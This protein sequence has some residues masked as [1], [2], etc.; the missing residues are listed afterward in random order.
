[1]LLR[2]ALLH[3]HL[4]TRSTSG[5]RTVMTGRPVEVQHCRTPLVA[6]E[7][8]TRSSPPPHHTSSGFASPWPSAG[9]NDL[10]KFLRARL[11]DWKET[12]LPDSSALPAVRACSWLPSSPSADGDGA[13]VFTWLGHAGCHFQIPLPAAPGEDTAV[14]TILTDPVFSKRCSPFQW[15]GPQR[16][17]DPPTSVAEMASSTVAHV[18]PDLLVLSHNHYDHLDHDTMKLLLS[19]PNGKPRPHI[20][21]P[22]GM[23]KWFEKYMSVPKEGVTELDWW[24]DRVAILD[25]NRRVKLTC[26]PA[27]HFSGR[28]L[29]D[30]DQTLW[31]GWTFQALG[32]GDDDDKQGKR[33]Y[34]AGDTG[35]RT[36]PPGSSREDEERLPVCPA[37]TEIGQLLGPFD[38]AAIP[39]GA[40]LPRSFMSAIHVST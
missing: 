39:I 4:T 19:R 10:L 2:S 34:F 33:V 16:Y 29:T 30:R 13:V 15:L 27:Q 32:D 37:F 18:W 17:T 24:Q 38:F 11:F 23:A 28:G 3:R 22:L 8:Y 12:P 31:A 40:Y 1:M 7:F 25:G 5:F 14:V 21:C 20:F 9:T 35:Y 26:V 6:P 36:V